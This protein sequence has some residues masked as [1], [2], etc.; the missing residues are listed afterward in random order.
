[1]RTIKIYRGIKIGFTDIKDHELVLIKKIY[2]CIIEKRPKK[3]VQ[4]LDKL[5]N[6]S[7]TNSEHLELLAF[8]ELA[9]EK[10]LIYVKAILEL[11]QIRGISPSDTLEKLDTEKLK[12]RVWSRRKRQY[13]CV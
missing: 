12:K 1:M 2:G 6:N 3:Y 8:N 4:L 5:R 11:S 13:P 10:Q 7:L 9:E